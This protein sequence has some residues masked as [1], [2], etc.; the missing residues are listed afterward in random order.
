MMA[1][2]H[3]YVIS[4][5]RNICVAAFSHAGYAHVPLHIAYYNEKAEQTLAG[6][7]LPF[8]KLR[9]VIAAPQV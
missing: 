6:C 1:L 8:P 2:Q 4:K 3:I 9:Q 5:S 7:T